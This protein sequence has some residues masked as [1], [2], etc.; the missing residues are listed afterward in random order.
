VNPETIDSEYAKLEQEVQATGQA[1]EAMSQKLQPA[2]SAGD[3]NAREWLLDLKSIALQVQQDHLQMQALM[4]A[5]HDFTVSHLSDPGGG[6]GQ[7]GQ[8]AYA[9][10]PAYAMQQPMGGGGILSRF[11]GGGFGRAIVTG[12]GFGIGDDI[13]NAIL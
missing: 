13:I 12:A 3:A 9:P 11:M 10:Q 8:P 5:M 6:Y 2:A 1:I 4:Q 7:Q